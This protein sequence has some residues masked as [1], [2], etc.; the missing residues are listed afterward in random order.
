MKKNEFISE[1]KAGLSKLSE[2]ETKERLIFYSEMIDDKIEEG[3][4]EE[5]AVASIDAPKDIAAQIMRDIKLQKR[6]T[7]EK[8]KLKPWEITVL[9]LGSPLWI[10]LLL[11]AA[12][13]VLTI[14]A[15]MFSINLVLWALEIPFFI[16]SLLSQYLII[17]C[18]SS[19]KLTVMLAKKFLGCVK[20]FFFGKDRS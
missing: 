13:V 19:T 17:A 12:A 14:F 3:L 6:K 9:I 8:R 10:T 1:L 2:K 7:K 18:K 20:G 16:F 11:V 15:V 4:S 5:Q